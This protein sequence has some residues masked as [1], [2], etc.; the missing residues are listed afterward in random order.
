MGEDLVDDILVF[1]KDPMS[2]IKTLKEKY[3]LK[4]VGMP[5]YYLGGNVEQLDDAW[6]LGFCS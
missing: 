1:S 4:G 5:E 2:I 6:Q 3:V